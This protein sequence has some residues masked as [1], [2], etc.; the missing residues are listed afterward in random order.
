M[1]AGVATSR[2]RD[3]PEKHRTCPRRWRPDDLLTSL[4][5]RNAR[6]HRHRRNAAA[7]RFVTFEWLLDRS[8]TG[9]SSSKKRRACG[10]SA[11]IGPRGDRHQ[12]AVWPAIDESTTLGGYRDGPGSV[13]VRVG[14]TD[15]CRES[16]RPCWR[17]TARVSKVWISVESD[18]QRTCRRA[19]A[20]D[21][22]RLWLT[23]GSH[24]LQTRAA[25]FGPSE[26]RGDP[27]THARTSR[28]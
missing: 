20:S 4:R 1:G 25:F 17:S 22:P 14:D 26:R 9:G 5:Q 13:G 11:D 28:T 18:R 15:R 2:Q 10:R 23:R 16:P 3:S 12:R 6:S 21:E 7:R 8:Q 24:A 19:S 27:A